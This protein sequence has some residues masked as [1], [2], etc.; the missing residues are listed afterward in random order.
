MLECAFGADADDAAGDADHRR[1]VRDM[2][3]HHRSGADLDVIADA[4]VA[5][6]L[7]AGA[8]HHAVAEGGMALAALAAG[9]AQRH[10]LVEQHVVADLG[11]FA[12]HHAGAVVDEEAAADGGAGVDLDLGEEAADLRNHARQQRHAPAVKPVGQAVRQ[13][14]VKA[15]DSRGRSRGHSWPPGLPGRWC[16]SVPGWLETC[17]APMDDGAA[18]AIR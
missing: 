8:D 9:A 18:A 17:R 1:V 7:G 6:H 13:D 4:D 12:D 15:R 5:E 14:G 3:D 10:A 2:V 11:G 16:R